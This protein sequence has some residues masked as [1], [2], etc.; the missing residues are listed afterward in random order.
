[1]SRRAVASYGHSASRGEGSACAGEVSGL[2]LSFA[3]AHLGSIVLSL[4]GGITTSNV[5]VWM[6]V[7]QRRE[8]QTRSCKM[9][10]GPHAHGGAALADEFGG[11]TTVL[12]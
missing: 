11:G 2:I 3:R 6:Q 4:A 12:H 10:Q 7:K 8:F 9:L 1:M 5:Y